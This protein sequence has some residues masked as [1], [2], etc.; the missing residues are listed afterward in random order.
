MTTV[1]MPFFSDWVGTTF[2]ETKSRHR[3]RAL[4]ASERVA[5]YC[6]YASGELKERQ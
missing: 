2:D 4:G 3:T 1:V 6:R 5:G